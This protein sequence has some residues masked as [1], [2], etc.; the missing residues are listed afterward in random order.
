MDLFLLLTAVVL[1]IIVLVGFLNEK[2]F[3]LTYEIVLLLA[4]IFVGI[5]M[6]AA[7][8]VMKNTDTA[9]ILE[10]IQLFNLEDFLINGVL[11]FMLFAGS[12]HLRLGQF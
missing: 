6:L 8:S 1:G 7:V 2:I 4:S 3:H 10:N 5:C 9:E 11:C 12:Y